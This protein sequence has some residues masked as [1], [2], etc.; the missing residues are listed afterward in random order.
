M[1]SACSTIPL[2]L[3]LHTSTIIERTTYDCL[4]VTIVLPDRLSTVEL[5]QPCNVVAA[6]RDQ[7]CR[8]SGEGSV[9][10]PALVS[11]EGLLEGEV[12]PRSRPDLD[13]GVS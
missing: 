10:Y 2:L 1:I 9:P 3:S 12:V 5:P 11:Y 6:G 13:G 7:V 8:V 4:V